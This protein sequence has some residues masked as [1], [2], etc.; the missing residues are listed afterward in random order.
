MLNR[1]AVGA[2][3]PTGFAQTTTSDVIAGVLTFA[4]ALLRK[5]HFMR[6][7]SGVGDLTG[8]ANRTRFIGARNIGGSLDISG[9]LST[10][11]LVA[12][13]GLTRLGQHLC[14]R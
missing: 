13:R 14:N 8:S 2:V 5:V 10:L 3:T 11:G 6:A 1:A 4:G 9:L 12:K 7:E